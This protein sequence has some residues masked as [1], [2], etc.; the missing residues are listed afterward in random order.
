[1]DQDYNQ[2]DE[3]SAP[4]GNFLYPSANMA[5]NSN[6]GRGNHDPQLTVNSFHLQSTAA[7]GDHCSSFQP[8]G[9]HQHHH[10]PIVKT[11]ASTSHHHHVQKFH[12]PNLMTRDHHQT[13]QQVHDHHQLP[14]DHDHDHPHRSKEVEAIKAKI[15]AHPQYSNLLEAYMDCQKVYLFKIKSLY[16]N[17]NSHTSIY[18]ARLSSASF[19]FIYFCF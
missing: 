13:V 2:M 8:S 11:E 1:M 5:A 18:E 16:K 12:Y 9:P 19:L 3:N 4:R 15:I 10:Q 17:F 6:Y 7:G 14:E